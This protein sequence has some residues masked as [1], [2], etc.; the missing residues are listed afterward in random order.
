MIMLA[1]AIYPSIRRRDKSAITVIMAATAFVVAWL[2]MPISCNLLTSGRC[3]IMMGAGLVSEGINMVIQ[4]LLMIL[5]ALW[6]LLLCVLPF[7]DVVAK[8]AA[9]LIKSLIEI[10][11]HFA[12][13]PSL[14]RA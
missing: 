14:R 2:F 11:G 9:D 6:V 8:E 4:G 12:P 13:T 3:M 7:L 5:S 10:V 1:L